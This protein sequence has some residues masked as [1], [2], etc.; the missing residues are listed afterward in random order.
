MRF[1]EFSTKNFAYYALIGAKDELEAIVYYT[2]EVADIEESDGQPE[3]IT[4]ELALA[5]L[6]SICKD[7]DEMKEAKD[8]FNEYYTKNDKPYLL[9]IDSC[10]L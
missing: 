10:L 6:L 8:E 7:T 4:K 9:L 1:Y 3:E 2:G 5:K